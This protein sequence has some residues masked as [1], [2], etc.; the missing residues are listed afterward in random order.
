MALSYSVPLNNTRLAKV[1]TLMLLVRAERASDSY[2][3]FTGAKQHP[4]DTKIRTWRVGNC[5]LRC[6]AINVDGNV[7]PG[8][9]ESEEPLRAVGRAHPYFQK[10]IF[11][12]FPHI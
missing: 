5:E 7:I 4:S 12:C 11:F 10:N 2:F 8:I 1:A 6:Q 9:I 3:R